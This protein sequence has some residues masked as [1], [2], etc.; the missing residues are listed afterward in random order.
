MKLA[1]MGM[2][3]MRSSG[4]R[5]DVPIDF[6]FLD[7]LQ[8]AADDPEVGLGSFAQGVRVGPGVRIPRLPAL[9]KRKKKWSL[10][11][12]AD[13]RNYLEEEETGREHTWRRNYASLDDLSDKVLDVLKDQ[14]RRGQS[15][16]SRRRTQRVSTRTWWSRL[17]GPTE[18]TNPQEKFQLASFFMAPTAS[19]V[20]TRTRIR[21]QERSP[22]ASDLKRAMREK[23][24]LE[25]GSSPDRRGH[26]HRCIHSNT[27][28]S[29]L[30]YFTSHRSMHIEKG[31]QGRLPQLPPLS[32]SSP[33]SC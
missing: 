8:R 10:P 22:V 24:A 20:N 26:A 33:C 1:S 32:W 21:D 17:S 6:L 28:T 7:L 2:D 3:L 25:R 4:D 14:T 31:A 18:R 13:P 5:N 27:S 23:A 16:S 11:S 12:Q 29:T 9:Y 15:S 19:S 30:F